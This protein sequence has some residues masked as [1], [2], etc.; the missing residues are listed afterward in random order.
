[1]VGEVNARRH[2]GVLTVTRGVT[3]D[4]S[5]DPKKG[6][7]SLAGP[8]T[9]HTTSSSY[10]DVIRPQVVPGSPHEDLLR[11]QVLPR[12]VHR[13]P[14]SGCANRLAERAP[15]G[16]DRQEPPGRPRPRFGGAAC[17]APSAA[18]PTP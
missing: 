8:P 6:L 10:T 2:A 15:R 13:R 18:T 9:V 1:M 5:P 4:F 16:P 7:H 3:C 11:P 17:T 12:T 14:L